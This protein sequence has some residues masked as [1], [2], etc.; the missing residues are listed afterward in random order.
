[1]EGASHLVRGLGGLHR[2][3]RHLGREMQSVAAVATKL[4]ALPAIARL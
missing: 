3:A 2:S 1:V 4:D